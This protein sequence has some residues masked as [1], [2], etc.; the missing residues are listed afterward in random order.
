MTSNGASKGAAPAREGEGERE[1]EAAKRAEEMETRLY[2]EATKA[3][4]VIFLIM[5]MRVF[6]LK[7]F[8]GRQ[9]QA[10]AVQLW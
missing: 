2:K 8:N 4:A 7:V 5:P 3:A 9:S 1:G 6:C 10:H